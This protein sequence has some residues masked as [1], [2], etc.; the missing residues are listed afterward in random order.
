MMDFEEMILVG[1]H[2]V[3]SLHIPAV[4]D[5]PVGLVAGDS[6]VDPGNRRGLAGTDKHL[7]TNECK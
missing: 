3:V 1:M 2:Q 5:N 7:R 4:G 6:S